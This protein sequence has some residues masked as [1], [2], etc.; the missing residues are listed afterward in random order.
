MVLMALDHVRVYSGVPAG[1]AEPAVFF[2][3]WVTHFCAP[4]FAFLAG[5]SAYLQGAAVGRAALSRFLL[6]RGLLLILLELTLIKASWTFTLDYSELVLAGVIWMLGACMVAMAA[7]VHLPL[8]AVGVIGLLVM[9]CQQLFGRVRAGWGWELIYPSGGEVPPPLVV[10]YTVLPWLGVMMAGYACGAL[11]RA[12][13]PGRSRWFLGLGL[14]A[15][16]V[17][18]V[19]ATVTTV[20]A[21]RGE[22]PPL[23]QA[24]HQQKYPPSQLF[25]LMTLGPLLAFVPLAERSSSRLSRALATFGRVPMFFYLCHIPLIHLLALGVSWVR[26]VDP[27]ARYASA[28]YVW[29]PEPERWSLGLLYATFVV[30]VALLYPLCRWVGDLKAAR[31]ARWLRYV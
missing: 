19:A 17:F 18:V 24:L 31:R 28:P 2:T 13:E 4:A 21:P 15:V 20:M 27:R 9:A 25:L 12:P 11:F 22:L 16:G 30:A 26:G 3:R 23:L 10:L 1:G 5:T 8:R 7:L 14:A 6:G 29:M